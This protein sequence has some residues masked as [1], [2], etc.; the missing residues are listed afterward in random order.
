M[1]TF[2]KNRFGLLAETVFF[3]KVKLWLILYI[4]MSLC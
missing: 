3:K 1:I 2:I 4:E